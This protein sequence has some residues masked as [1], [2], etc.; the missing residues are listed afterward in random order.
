MI[1]CFQSL[2]SI[3][4]CAAT[5]GRRRAL[6]ARPAR[7]RRGAQRQPGGA[8][9]VDPIK[10]KLKP[11]GTNCL[12]LKCDKLLSTSAFKFNLRRYNLASRAS[13]VRSRAAALAHAVKQQQ[14]SQAASS[15]TSASAAA[16]LGATATAAAASAAAYSAAAGIATTERS[17]NELLSHELPRGKDH[18]AHSVDGQVARAALGVAR[19]DKQLKGLARDLH[20]VNVASTALLNT[21][22]H[23]VTAA[24]GPAAMHW[25][26]LDALLHA[27]C[28]QA[29]KVGSS[30]GQA[31]QI[32]PGAPR[33]LG[34][35][36]CLRLKT[37]I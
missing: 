20:L 13:P 28:A 1:N 32:E 11:P 31:V 23:P 15:S 35:M 34:F 36:T 29:T 33:A 2:L 12:T 37:M 30:R 24:C 18:A 10:P 3:S 6:R 16:S 26:S 8:V 25:S 9:Q 22:I 17:W 14:R 27:V 19:G 21:H 5:A 7:R 4:T